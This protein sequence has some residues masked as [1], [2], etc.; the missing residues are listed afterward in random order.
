MNNTPRAKYADAGKAQRDAMARLAA[1]PVTPKTFTYWQI[2]AFVVS[3]VGSWSRLRDEVRRSEVAERFGVSSRT[4]SRAME[5]AAANGILEW[6]AGE[7]GRA[8]IAGLTPAHIQAVSVEGS[9]DDASESVQS[10]VDSSTQ[11]NAGHRGCFENDGDTFPQPHIDDFESLI[12]RHWGDKQGRITHTL[13]ADCRAL[14]DVWT[15][16]QV[17]RLITANVTSAEFVG[18][19]QARLDRVSHHPPHEKAM[20]DPRLKGML[21]MLGKP[22]SSSIAGKDGDFDNS[23]QGFSEHPGYGEVGT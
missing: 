12:R 9:A 1:V 10:P 8:W 22:R 20:N 4:V 21:G 14:L 11:E 18:A 15:R 6:T 23:G 19:L 3:T 2:A 5:W 7:P 13:V 16:G 17:E